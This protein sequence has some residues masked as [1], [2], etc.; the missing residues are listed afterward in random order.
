MVSSLGIHY[1][2]QRDNFLFL[3]DKFEEQEQISL[4]ANLE[5]APILA[6]NCI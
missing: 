4:N 6:N 3:F 1:T 5:V 2:G